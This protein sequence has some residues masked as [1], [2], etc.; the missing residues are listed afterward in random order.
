MRGV[1]LAGIMSLSMLSFNAGCV[2]RFDVD[3]GGTDAGSGLDHLSVVDANSQT[4]SQVSGQDAAHSDLGSGTDHNTT[5]DAAHSDTFSAS[6]TGA[7][8][9]T[10]TDTGSATDSNQDVPDGGMPLGAHC[11]NAPCGDA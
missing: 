7:T 8:D 2:T 5:H 4:D 11:E 10:V 1:F 9:T 6:D 3:A